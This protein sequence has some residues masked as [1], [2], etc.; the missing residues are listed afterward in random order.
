MSSNLEQIALIGLGSM[1]MGIAR[2]LLRV[3]LPIVGY[4]LSDA[5]RRA[6][7]DDGGQVADSIAEAADGAGC[8]ISVVVN[9]AQTESVIGEALPVMAADGVFVSC[10]TIQTAD[11]HALAAIVE[12]TGRQYLDAPISGG[13]I[14][15]NA[16]Q[17]T[18]M[19]SGT[20]AAFAKA[21]PALDAMAA[22]VFRLGDSAGAGSSMKTINQLLCGV[23]IA[24]A[25][26]AVALAIKLGLDPE[27]V[28]DVITKAAGTSWIFED[29]V[30]HILEGD[31]APRSAI[32]IFVKDMGIV[33]GTGTA[34]KFPTPMASAAM[35]LYL[36]TSAA[37]MGGD[38]DSSVV[39]LY[40]KLAG[41]DLPGA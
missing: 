19:A 27:T 39:R 33:V 10:A 24:A 16:G 8:V 11:A 41:L 9:A 13:S 29:R 3:G 37:G 22:N 32:D 25:C 23:H 12:A 7:A 31:Y 14:K 5:A 36:M 28:H 20:A 38:D 4:D 26:E 34:E 18:V 17:I 1:G 30:P 40:A 15:A 6:F 21:Q 35:Q 2:S